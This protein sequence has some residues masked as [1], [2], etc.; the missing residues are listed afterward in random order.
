MSSPLPVIYLARH[1]ETKWSLSGQHTGLTDLPLTERGEEN[2]RALRKRLSGLNFGKV[3]TSGIMDNM[4]ASPLLRSM[5]V[6]RIGSC[7][8]TAA[9]A[10]NRPNKSG[11]GLRQ[12]WTG[13]AFLERMRSFFRVGIFCG[14]LLPAGWRLKLWPENTSY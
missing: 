5:P 10:G 8:V 3:F 6:I 2:A 4:R 7:S 12:W 14:C 13:C 1:G 9:R 11:H